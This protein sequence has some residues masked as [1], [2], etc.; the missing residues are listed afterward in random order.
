MTDYIEARETKRAVKLRARR[1]VIFIAVIMIV[2]IAVKTKAVLADGTDSFKNGRSNSIF[3][4][5][6]GFLE[7]SESRIDIESVNMKIRDLGELTTAELTSDGVLRYEKGK[8]PIITKHGF[9]MTYSSTVR[10]GIDF[11]RVKAK[12]RGIE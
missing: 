11:S 6:G 3:D 9:L 12:V 5:K 2:V 10:A 8:I 7:P 4:Q 1:A